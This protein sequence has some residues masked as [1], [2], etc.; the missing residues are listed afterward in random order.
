MVHRTMEPTPANH[1]AAEGHERLVDVISFIESRPESAELMQQGQGLLHHVTE[2]AQAAAMFLPPTGDGRGDVATRQLHSVGIGVISPVAH[3]FL[4]LA[5]RR[6]RLTANRRNCID[7]RDQL[8]H[9]V[10][11]GRGENRGKR[12]AAGIDDDMMFRAVFPAVHGTWSR[13][14]PPCTARTYA[15]STITREKSISLAP[16]SLSSNRWWSWSQTPACRHSS[17]RFHRVMPQQPISCGKSSH[18]RPVLST[19]MIPVRQTRS[20]TRGLQTPGMY[21]CLGSIGSTPA[22]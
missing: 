10:A 1:R 13:F 8:R 19:K 14:F 15:E 6:A 4:R 18:G 3:H 7:Q 5:Q 12:H 21:G 2:D 16:R 9:V 17:R 20:G 22:P 11:I